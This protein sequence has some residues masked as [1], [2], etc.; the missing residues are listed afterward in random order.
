MALACVGMVLAVCVV[1]EKVRLYMEESVV[2][3]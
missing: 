1:L 2:L 3:F